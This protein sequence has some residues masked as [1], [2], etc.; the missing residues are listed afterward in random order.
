[1]YFERCRITFVEINDQCMVNYLLLEG[2]VI[3]MMYKFNSILKF[4][5][6]FLVMEN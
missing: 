6:V 3:V 4:F 5:N 1:M 2:V